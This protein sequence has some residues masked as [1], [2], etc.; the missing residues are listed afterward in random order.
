MCGFCS[1]SI[2]E[3][4]SDEEDDEGDLILENDLTYTPHLD[5]SGT[6]GGG[7]SHRPLP[8]SLSLPSSISASL[9]HHGNA[10]HAPR[11]SQDSMRE[12]GNVI[13]L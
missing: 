2:A 5:Q 4:D 9:S 3:G 6:N 7:A 11:S 10:G 13:T 1:S 12:D 8:Q